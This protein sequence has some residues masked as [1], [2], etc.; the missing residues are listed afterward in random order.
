MSKSHRAFALIF[1]MIF[2]GSATIPI[3]FN[4]QSV[5]TVTL[6]DA[7]HAPSATDYVVSVRVFNEPQDFND[8]D[9]EFTV[10]NGSIPLS[11]AT[12]SL[13]NASTMMFK[14]NYTT[15]GIGEVTLH[16]LAQ[17]TYQWNVSHI[18]DSLTPYV[19]GQIVSDGPEAN[20]NILFGNVDWDNDEDDLNAT[21]T[22][23]EDRPANNLNF[24]IHFNVNDSI[25]AQ[26][27]VTDGRADFEDIPDGDYIWRLSVLDDIFYGGFILD[28]GTIEA[29]STQKLVLE[30]LAEMTGNPDYYDLEIF[31][32]FE[33]SYE[34]I[35]GALVNVTYKNGSAYDVKTTPNNGTVIFT[36]LPVDYMNWTVTYGGLPI[37]FGDYFRNLTAV[38]Y[39][40]R[41]PVITSPGNQDILFDAENVTITWT[42]QDEYP[43]TIE[44]FIDG[45][46]S[47]S[48]A[49]VN[50][51]YDYVFN[52]SAAFEELLI[53]EYEIKLIVHDQGP[54]TAE[55]IIQLKI[56]EDVF[57]EIEGPEDVEFY[58]TETGYSLS[59]NVTD[60][61]LYMYTVMNND[62]VVVSGDIDPDEPVITVN[63]DG[64]NIGVHNFTLSAND[65]SGNTAYNSTIV[66][67]MQDDIV[68]IIVFAPDDISYSQG[69]SNI[70][71][72]WTATDEYKDYY[73]ITVATT[74]GDT[75]DTDEVVHADW[76]TEN[77]EFDFAGLLAGTHEVIL[78]VYDIG[79][80][81]VQSIVT[82]Q[83]AIGSVG[84]IV[85]IAVIWFIRYR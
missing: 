74:I 85:L 29:N 1:L 73:T 53:G 77:I 39:D 42:L 52:V 4:S 82:V 37:G 33:T 20:V 12:V 76:I 69:D 81:S 35:V 84:I 59:W 45:N 78:T 62:E 38:S 57:P 41:T 31:T 27:E 2:V 49:W 44:V 34:P 47:I 26:T 28:S 14:D 60:D 58:F 17:G 36:D 51:T 8:D 67:V 18:D 71:R 70:I 7:P 50:T 32:Y 54:L 15:D 43:D 5:T 13:Y 64:L 16:N 68:P 21:I 66:T 3:A 24:S 23:I 72:N 25:W 79:G 40:I 11:G 6:V 22:D 30:T 46:L 55:D 83:M 63:L 80:N 48:I 19:T 10:L 75:I 61:N 65:T 56:Y 9:F